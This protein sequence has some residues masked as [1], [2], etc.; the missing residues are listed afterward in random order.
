M[1]RKEISSTK[2]QN[3]GVEPAIIPELITCIISNYCYY[4]INNNNA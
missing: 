4:V 2:I 3:T 1:V